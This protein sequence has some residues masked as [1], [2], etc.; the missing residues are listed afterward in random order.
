ME[1]AR[2][3]L[4]KLNVFA[5]MLNVPNHRAADQA[6][7]PLAAPARMNRRYGSADYGI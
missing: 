3:A 7:E 6:I 1:Q 2:E 5:E 4:K